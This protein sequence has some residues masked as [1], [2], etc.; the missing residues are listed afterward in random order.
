MMPLILV[1]TVGIA[2]AEPATRPLRIIADLALIALAII[3]FK[4]K[5]GVIL[6][7]E[8]IIFFLLLSPLLQTLSIFPLQMF[9]YPLFIVPFAGFAI[10][11]P[12]SLLF[13]YL[14]YRQM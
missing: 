4:K 13:S 5:T 7:L 14:D 6:I 9:A 3:D 11:Y 8:S 2:D 1:L 10:L 12:L